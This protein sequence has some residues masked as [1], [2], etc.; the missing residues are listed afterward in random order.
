MS[1]YPNIT[2]VCGPYSRLLCALP[3][4]GL[5]LAPLGL[6]LPVEPPEVE[7]VL[8]VVA[9]VVRVLHRNLVAQVHSLGGT[10]PA[11]RKMSAG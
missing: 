3:L 9:D 10:G 8:H 2:V 11:L 5:A 6:S 1:Q 7:Q 4:P